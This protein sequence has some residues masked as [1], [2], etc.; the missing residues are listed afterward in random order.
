VAIGDGADSGALAATRR[1]E[2]ETVADQSHGVQLATI[3]QLVRYWQTD[4]DYERW[5]RG[6]MP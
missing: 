5:K 3:K 1:P 2:Q 4:Y 6:S